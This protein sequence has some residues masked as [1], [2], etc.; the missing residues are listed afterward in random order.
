[1]E[2]KMSNNWNNNSQRGDEPAIEQLWYTWSPIGLSSVTAGFRIRAA[3]GSLR[4]VTSPRVKNLDQY[5]RYTLP[6]GADRFNPSSAPICLSLLQ[7][8]DGERILLNKTYTGRD[9]QGRPGAFFVHLLANLPNNFTVRDAFL[10]WQSKFWESSDKSIGSDL[11]LKPTSLNTLQHDWEFQPGNVDLLRLPH[12][13]S[14]E[15]RDFLPLFI[16]A[17]LMWRKGWEYWRNNRGHEQELPRFYIAISADILG[18]FLVTLALCLPDALLENVTFSTYEKDV[19]TDTHAMIIGTTFTQ[20]ML[21]AGRDLPPSCYETGVALNCYAGRG[22]TLENS[23]L[24]A[25]FANYVTQLVIQGIPGSQ[26]LKE[27]LDE[28]QTIPDMNV[29]KFLIAYE[30]IVIKGDQPDKGSLGSSLKNRAVMRLKRSRVQDSAITFAMED[31]VWGESVLVKGLADLTTYSIAYRDNELAQVLYSFGV[32]AARTIPTVI[33]RGMTGGSILMLIMGSV[34]ATSDLTHSPNVW[35]VLLQEIRPI[36]PKKKLVYFKNRDLYSLLDKWAAILPSV[37]PSDVEP[38]LRVPW[39]SNQESE[40]FFS[41]SSW[42]AEWMYTALQADPISPQVIQNPGENF[43]R[44]VERVLTYLLEKGDWNKA[45]ELFGK[46]VHSPYRNIWLAILLNSP[47]SAGRERYVIDK[48]PLSVQERVWFLKQYGYAYLS[49]P[50]RQAII[51]EQFAQ[52]QKYPGEKK[53]VLYTWLR[54]RTGREAR[55]QQ[56]VAWLESPGNGDNLEKLLQ[57]ASLTPDESVDFLEEHGQYYLSRYDRPYRTSSRT[58]MAQ[59][60]RAYLKGLSLDTFLQASIPTQRFV[61]FLSNECGPDLPPDIQGIFQQFSNLNSLFSDSVNSKDMVKALGNSIPQPGFALIEKLSGELARRVTNAVE[62]AMVISTVSSF[63]SYKGY[64]F[65]ILLGMA[66]I[67]R[68]E[69]PL[70]KGWD[71]RL[72]QYVNFVLYADSVFHGIFSMDVQ[73]LFREQFLDRLLE[74]ASDEILDKIEKSNSIIWDNATAIKWSAY[75]EKRKRFQPTRSGALAPLPPQYN[76]SGGSGANNASSPNPYLLSEGRRPSQQ[77]TNVQGG[78]QPIRFFSP[79]TTQKP[80]RWA[81]LTKFFNKMTGGNTRSLE[82]VKKGKKGNKP[83]WKI[84]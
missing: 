43:Q 20:E 52:L 5:L 41:H 15:V 71:P 38:F 12:V 28:V 35:N 16:R 25:H 10:L 66:E 46:V 18:A 54:S 84:I 9:G 26:E 40:V 74:S 24:A 58:C 49:H 11:Y 34:E 83:W 33:E 80:S 45:I 76:A 69:L 48:V 44:T 22:T 63:P 56:F 67:V 82:K 30:D 79:E 75:R 29:D 4:E 32:N 47:L 3:S 2:G 7:S 65:Q 14:A 17:Y 72:I 68:D 70:Y 27:F 6:D 73:I 19:L 50:Q 55:P 42:P 37:N 1:M 39:S 21:N 60:I 51:L 53:D 31:L 57:S 23:P 62:L 59:Y 77:L 81:P 8:V 64:L 13:S 36:S 61:S 78:Q